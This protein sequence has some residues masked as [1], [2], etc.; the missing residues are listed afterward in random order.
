MGKVRKDKALSF[1]AIL[2]LRNPVHWHY[3]ILSAPYKFNYITLHDNAY[4]SL[5]GLQTDQ[6]D[7][8]TVTDQRQN[9]TTILRPLYRLAYVSRH[10]Q[11]RI[12]KQT[13][14]EQSFTAAC[15]S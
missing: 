13:L 7:N 11:L 10:H 8:K 6:P 5:P 3:P 14:L 2:R 12:G 15:P 9:T 1:Y 4:C